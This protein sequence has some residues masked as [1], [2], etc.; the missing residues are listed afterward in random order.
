MYVYLRAQSNISKYN[1][2]YDFEGLFGSCSWKWN[3]SYTSICMEEWSH[4]FRKHYNEL[5]SKIQEVSQQVEK[6]SQKYVVVNLH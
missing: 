6:C 1:I 4:G 3:G 5:K 2:N